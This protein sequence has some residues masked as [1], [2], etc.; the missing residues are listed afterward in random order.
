MQIK[1]SKEGENVKIIYEIMHGEVKTARVDTQGHCEIYDP[2]MMPYNLYLDDTEE[3]I[4][5]LVNNVTN[6]Y[7]WCEMCI[8]DRRYLQS[9][10]SGTGQTHS[11]P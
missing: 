5:T 10:W 1:S 11:L 3:E 8:R 6:F 7:F 9:E 4:D 2:V